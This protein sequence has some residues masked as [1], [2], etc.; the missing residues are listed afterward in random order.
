MWL[1]GSKWARRHDEEWQ[2]LLGHDDH[3]GGFKRMRRGAAEK[4]PRGSSVFRLVQRMIL[5]WVNGL[6]RVNAL[7]AWELVCAGKHCAAARHRIRPILW[8]R[9]GGVCS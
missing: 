7:G 8:Q 5:V 2:A 4:M 1:V 6:D 3:W 9:V